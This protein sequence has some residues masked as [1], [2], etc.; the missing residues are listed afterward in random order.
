LF[1]RITLNCVLRNSDVHLKNFGVLYEEVPREPRL[2]PVYDISS[3]PLL[4]CRYAGWQSHSREQRDGLT[5]TRSPRVRN[6]SRCACEN[7]R[8]SLRAFQ[9][10]YRRP[11]WTSVRTC[12]SSTDFQE[13]GERMIQQWEVRS[14]VFSPKREDCWGARSNELQRPK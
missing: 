2:A 12:R 10:Q 1:T 14:N 9:R 13:I 5:R 3:R 8:D 7:S 6:P 11:L 4:G